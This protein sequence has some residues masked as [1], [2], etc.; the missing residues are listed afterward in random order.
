M[1]LIRA[2]LAGI[3]ALSL[4]G[5]APSASYFVNQE[6]GSDSSAG[7]LA[8]PFLTLGKCA[9]A[10]SGTANAGCAVYG[11][12]TTQSVFPE[13]FECSAKS[14][15]LVGYGNFQPQLLGLNTISTG[16][17]SN[18][19]GA[20]YQ[21]TVTTA[22]QSGIGFMNV[23]ENGAAMPQTATSLAALVSGGMP[24]A[25]ISGNSTLS[26]T[27]F[28]VYVYATGG[29]NPAS[30][31]NAYQYAARNEGVGCLQSGFTL[32]NV[33]V[34][35][36]LA[37]NGPLDTTG[38]Y[39]LMT[40]VTGKNGTKHITVV[41]TG[42]TIQSS[43]FSGAYY[44]GLGTDLVTYNADCPNGEGVTFKNLNISMPVYGPG[45]G[46]IIGHTNTC[47][48]AVFGLVTYSG[49]RLND[50]QGGLDCSAAAL[51]A[52]GGITATNVQS[53]LTF[54]SPGTVSGSNLNSGTT[55]NAVVIS[56]PVAVTF[57]GTNT[58]SGASANQAAIYASGQAATLTIGAGTTI[59]NPNANG[60]GIVAN[61]VGTVLTLS[62]VG[63]TAQNGYQSL[64]TGLT[65]NN[66][67]FSH[68]ADVNVNA[69]YYT[70]AQACSTFGQE[71]NSTQ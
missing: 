8:A 38:S 16:A 60:F 27:G 3:V 1:Q 64:S 45:F 43:T 26:G 14:Q 17:W 52:I 50:L 66:N 62:G 20:V 34:E 2:W 63:I 19:S 31:G 48:S 11:G 30:N 6:R 56:A 13:D 54:F 67:T 22:N 61:A 10:I 18:Y 41:G 28:T 57:S 42:S 33:D 69:A 36:G 40:S 59:T 65:S 25:F 49:I 9:T 4:C 51:C 23:V 32:S 29:G 58:I 47:P 15:Y 24:G 35:W 7:S 21:A 46:G 71:C 37:N 55:G 39:L 44:A 12:T 68:T 5:Q 53:A 70:L